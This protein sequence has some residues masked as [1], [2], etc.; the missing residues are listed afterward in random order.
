MNEKGQ[1]RYETGNYGRSGSDG[2]PK[3]RSQRKD[4]PERTGRI[5]FNVV[6]CQGLEGMTK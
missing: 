1:N 4:D 5:N 2:R 3:T 6:G